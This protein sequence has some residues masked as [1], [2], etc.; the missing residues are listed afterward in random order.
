MVIAVASVGIALA[1]GTRL[2]N[3]LNGTF[4]QP[5]RLPEIFAIPV[6]IGIGNDLWAA[7][8][9]VAAIWVSRRLRRSDGHAAEGLI[10]VWAGA[11]MWLAALLEPSSTFLVALPLAWMATQAPRTVEPDPGGTYVRLLVPAL[12]IV[13]SLQVYPVGGATQQSVAALGLVPLGA[14]LLGDGIRQVRLAGVSGR[15]RSRRSW[16]PAVALLANVAVFALL[17]FVAFSEFQAGTSLGLRGAQSVRVPAVQGTD[18]RALVASIDRDCSSFITYPGMNSLYVWTAQSPP[19]EVSS[20][21]WWLEL[22]T[23]QQ[24][25]LVQQ[26]GGRQRLCVVKNQRAIDFWA[27]GR[28]VR[29][30]PLT[31]FIDREFVAAGWFGDYELLVRANQP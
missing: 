25:V 12:A 28:P 27:A 19:A 21:V 10:R 26:L 17:G 6:T 15:V 13:E 24:Q 14:L 8:S 4:V 16:V 2:D 23:Q 22:N 9:L 11:S 5:L 7:L 29:N 1:A 30:A 18:L 31:D 3:L 20:E